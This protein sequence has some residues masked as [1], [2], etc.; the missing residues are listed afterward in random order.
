MLWVFLS[1]KNN[2]W[3]HCHRRGEGQQ[4]SHPSGIVFALHKAP[5]IPITQDKTLLLFKNEEKKLNCLNLYLNIASTVF[6]GKNELS[7]VLIPSQWPNVWKNFSILRA[8]QRLC[9]FQTTSGKMHKSLLS[10]MNWKKVSG[11][12]STNDDHVSEKYIELHIQLM[13]H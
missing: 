12:Q 9:M 5:V 2:I 4:L 7:R 13:W 6:E 11:L 3:W 10:R 1:S 8:C